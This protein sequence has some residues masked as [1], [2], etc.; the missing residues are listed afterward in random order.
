MKY[1]VIHIAIDDEDDFSNEYYITG[2]SI[3]HVSETIK[4]YSN[5]YLSTNIFNLVTSNIKYGFI[6]EINLQDYPDLSP[7][8]F[9]QISNSRSYSL[10]DLK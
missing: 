8:D 9:A 4:K 3:E 10:L 1:F 7:C 5:G 6:R 2:K